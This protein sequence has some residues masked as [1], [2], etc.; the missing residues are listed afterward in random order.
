VAGASL[1]QHYRPPRGYREAVEAFDG[2]LLVATSGGRIIGAVIA[3]WDGWR[4]HLH[5][6]AVRPDARRQGVARALVDEAERRLI[7][8]GAKRISVLAHVYFTPTSSS[9]LNMVERFFRD[10]TQRRPRRGVFHDV[11]EL[12]MAIGDYVDQ[13]NEPPKPFIW[14]ASAKDI[15]AKV[16]RARAAQENR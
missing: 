15:L 14:T 5:H 8:R 2:H 16:S 1:A 6:L 10:L 9:W 7:A 12:I 13:H 4:G 11:E 3:G